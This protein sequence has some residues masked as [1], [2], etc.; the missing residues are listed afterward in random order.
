MKTQAN[1]RSMIETPSA[2]LDRWLWF[3]R[4]FK[5]RA[6]AT[7]YCESARIR[8]NGMPVAKAHHPIRPGDVLTFPLAVKVR[9]IRIVA[10]AARRGPA[11]EARLL[12]EDLTQPD[13]LPSGEGEGRV[14]QHCNGSRPM[15]GE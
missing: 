9:I 13:S 2:R 7:A 1:D 10:L 15:D 11:S 14:G 5:T 4:F 6:R 8:I 12:Y 3:A